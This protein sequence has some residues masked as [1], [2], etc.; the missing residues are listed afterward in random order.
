LPVGELVLQAPLQCD[1]LAIHAC[2]VWGPV[3]YFDCP[4]YLS[5]RK[6]GPNMWISRL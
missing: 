3:G 6:A 1:E 4:V 5:R 2:L